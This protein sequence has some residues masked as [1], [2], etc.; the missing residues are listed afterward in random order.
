VLAGRGADGLYRRQIAG[1][2][3]LAVA[4]G[5][6][7]DRTAADHRDG[8]LRKA[9]QHTVHLPGMVHRHSFRRF[10]AAFS[11]PRQRKP[12]S[13]IP[14]A[15]L[16]SFWAQLLHHQ[17]ARGAGPPANPCSTSS[18]WIYV[19]ASATPPEYGDPRALTRNTVGPGH[20]MDQG[21]CAHARR[22][23]TPRRRCC[24]I[25]AAPFLYNHPLGTNFPFKRRSWMG[26]MA[27]SEP[28]PS[29]SCAAGNATLL[30]L[31]AEYFIKIRLYGVG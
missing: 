5:V 21:G 16:P 31:G 7:H 20:R 29:R 3:P 4:S 8:Y 15:I 2:L 26:L 28:T 18:R 24:R 30:A 19:I 23:I 22:T 27:I 11:R 1:P 17:T 10:P 25:N 13:T 9:G 6:V 14:G 12:A